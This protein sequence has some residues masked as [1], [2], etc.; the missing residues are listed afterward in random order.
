MDEHA[1][2]SLLAARRS[3]VA[4]WLNK[5][6]FVTWDR[7]T[8]WT[9]EDRENT[10]VTVFG[11]ITRDDGRSDFVLMEF[12][13]WSETVGFSTS[14]AERSAEIAKILYGSDGNHFDCQRVEHVLG[15]LVERKIVLNV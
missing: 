10:G 7:L 13:S 14:S 4:E 2:G 1:H 3:W 15:D 9:T 6:P 5:L 11:W 8:E 12:T